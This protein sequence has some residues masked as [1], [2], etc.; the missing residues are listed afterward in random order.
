MST[1]RRQGQRGTE[2]WA[3]SRPHLR[4]STAPSDARIAASFA[5]ERSYPAASSSEA[6]SALSTPELEVYVAVC[7]PVIYFGR[8]AGF[9][10]AYKPKSGEEGVWKAV[11]KTRR[12]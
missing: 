4:H 5:R 1:G 9:E 6:S 8:F 10:A 12:N 11:P 2:K 3:G 7:T